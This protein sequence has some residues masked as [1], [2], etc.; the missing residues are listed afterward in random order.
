MSVKEP[1]KKVSIN[2]EFESGKT[3][4]AEYIIEGEHLNGK[5]FDKDKK[6]GIE[7]NKDEQK[8]LESFFKAIAVGFSIY[9]SKDDLI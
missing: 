2:I 6:E 8:E 3:F 7:L 4:D 9:K 1:L 5:F